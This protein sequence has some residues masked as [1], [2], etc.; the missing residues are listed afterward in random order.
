MSSRSI[1]FEK[2]KELTRRLVDRGIP[3]WGWR[4]RAGDVRGLVWSEVKLTSEGKDLPLVLDFNDDGANLGRLRQAA[5]AVAGDPYLW[6]SCDGDG[7][8][9]AIYSRNDLIVC[10][11][12]DHRASA[13]RNKGRC[14][15]G[16]PCND[17]AWS[18]YEAEAWVKVIEAHTEP[19]QAQSDRPC[20]DRNNADTQEGS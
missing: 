19:P 11:A 20:W 6:S 12:A 18:E 7:E 13:A 8:P 1:P 14:C 15:V 2:L 5:Q 3:T 16:G 17:P 9:W 10:G 4:A